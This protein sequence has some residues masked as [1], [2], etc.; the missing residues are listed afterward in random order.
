MLRIVLFL[1]TNLAVMLVLGV[2]MSIFGV[3]N[4]PNDLMALL[5]MCFVYGMVGS[6][7]SLF[8]SK[9]MA[10]MSTGTQIIEHPSTPAEQWLVQTV[11]QLAQQAGIKAPEVGIFHNP[12]SNAFATGWNKNAA[13]VAVS[14][15]LLERMDKDELKA[16]LGHEIGHVA[17]G[18]MVTMALIQG[19]LNA[20]VMFFARIIGNIVDRAIFKNDSNRPGIGYFVTS[21]VMDL[22]LGIVAS[23]IAMWFSR[24]REYRADAAGASLAG[25]QAMIDALQALGREQG[26]PDQMPPAMKS[27]A[28]AAGTESGFSLATLMRSHPTIEQRVAAL[29]RL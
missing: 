8:L 14:T 13:L 24:W 27:F 23:I 9:P 11:G 28:I 5:V 16:V 26:L 18:D 29:Q 3:T 25:K 10:K 19:V 22:L 4:N 20:F 17:N 21:M 7:V 15:G 1:A 2:V 12:Q 6:M